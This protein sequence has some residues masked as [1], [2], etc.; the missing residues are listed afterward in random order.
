MHNVNK[1]KKNFISN[2]LFFMLIGIQ[3]TIVEQFIIQYLNVKLY[4]VNYN[5][6]L[7]F[8]IYN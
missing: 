7:V 1:Q 4:E 3:N 8:I 6:Y 5:I 2:Y